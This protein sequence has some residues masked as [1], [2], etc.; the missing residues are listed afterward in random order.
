VLEEVPSLQRP[1]LMPCEFAVK[2]A[3]CGRVHDGAQTAPPF[4]AALGRDSGAPIG[5]MA[6]TE[7]RPR[8]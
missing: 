3:P 8:V 5:E 2:R 4:S 7:R 1:I 6:R